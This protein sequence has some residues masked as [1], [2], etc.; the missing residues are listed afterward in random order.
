[1]TLKERWL[2]QETRIGSWLK[3]WIGKL[4]I[5]A[6]ALGGA[7]EYILGLPVDWIPS[8]VKTTILIAGIVGF[9]GGKMTV[10]PGA[11]APKP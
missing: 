6:S 2:A 4:L 9:V 8:W 11:V 3:N 10:K 5:L 7:S 1:M